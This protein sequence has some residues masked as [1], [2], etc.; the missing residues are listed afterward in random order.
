MVWCTNKQ[1]VTS[2]VFFSSSIP[3]E[4]YQ[5][6][7]DHHHQVYE[8]HIWQQSQMVTV[9]QLKEILVLLYKKKPL[10]EINEK[11]TLFWNNSN[12]INFLSK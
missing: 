10:Q 9:I 11:W 7:L 4:V 8:R 12:K 1:S 3:Y 2:M 6:D 5:D